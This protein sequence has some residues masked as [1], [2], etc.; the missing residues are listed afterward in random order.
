MVAMFHD[1]QLYDRAMKVRMDKM[2]GSESSGSQG[3]PEKLPS[4]FNIVYLET[5]LYVLPRKIGKTH[6]CFYLFCRWIENYW[7]GTWYEWSTANEPRWWE[8]WW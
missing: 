4:T 5:I 2:G 6:C 1:Q 8:S 7:H 3:I